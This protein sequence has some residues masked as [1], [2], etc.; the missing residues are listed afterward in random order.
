MIETQELTQLTFEF[1]PY[2]REPSSKYRCLQTGPTV[3]KVLVN[4]A[5]IT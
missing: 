2:Q 5:D 4:P 1:V 3:Y